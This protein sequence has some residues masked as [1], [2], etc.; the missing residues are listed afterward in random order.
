ME[1]DMHSCAN[2]SVSSLSLPRPG[3]Q[4]TNKRRLLLVYVHGFMGSEASFHDLPA[5]LHNLLTSLLSESHVVYTRIY[6][7]Y[8]SHGEMRTAVHQFSAWLSPHEADDLDIILLGH[9]LGGI[10][11]ADVALLQRHRILGLINFD[12]PFLG[13]HP[14][15]IPT[16]IGASIPR[17][18]IPAEDKL[19]GEQDSLGMTPVYNPASNPNFDPPFQ[20]DVRLVDRGFF[21]G[22][23]HFVNKNVDN[24]SGSILNRVISPFK[25]AGC[26]N[27]FS[28]LRRRYRRILELEAA[29]NS[30]ERVRFVNYYTASTGRISRKTK[31]KPAEETEAEEDQIKH[32]STLP[33]RE[34][35]ETLDA[36]KEDE[37]TKAM[38]TLALEE[39]AP[40]PTDS[41]SA[42]VLE[43]TSSE[44]SQQAFV[45]NTSTTSLSSPD[46][47]DSHDLSENVSITTTESGLSSELSKKKLRKFILLPS[48]HWKYMHNS[49]WTP[50]LMEDMDEVEA[51][52]SMFIPHGANYD[53]LVGDTV[54]LIEQWVQDDLSRR[55][56]FQEE[57]D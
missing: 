31:A 20:N 39:E 35:S 17:K 47:K 43:E 51:H 50:I 41:D 19:A 11:A 40:E 5:H 30:P 29:E 33:S 3:P 42:V 25:F 49:H 38:S 37:A 52:Q 15:V 45:D 46:R 56:L 57:L 16:G 13:L 44:K 2:Y 34:K 14:R 12:V 36:S 53:H 4:D 1:G 48:H 23:M 10:V 26:V 54:A 8:K 6:P 27:N 9:S 22:M 7:R 21:K 32:T 18:D 28:E 55:L 24:L